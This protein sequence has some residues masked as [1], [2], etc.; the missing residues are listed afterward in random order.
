MSHHD[1]NLV[2]EKFYAEWKKGNWQGLG[3]LLADN[4]VDHNPVPNQK[5]GKQGMIDGLKEFL[6]AF[7]DM[8]ISGAL[9]VC[10]GDKVFDHGVARATHKG[11]LTG[12][13]ASNRPVEFTY[14]DMYR[15]ENGKIAEVWHV[16]DFVTVL[17]Q[18]GAMPAASGAQ[19][20]ASQPSTPTGRADKGR[21][22]PG[23]PS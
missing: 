18:I 19:P 21:S 6:Q 9:M 8:Q 22:Q 13:P 12:I 5:P 2:V 23:A 14:T 17:Q 3:A 7:P 15:I 11:T 16:E 4:V 20:P 10:E 1:N